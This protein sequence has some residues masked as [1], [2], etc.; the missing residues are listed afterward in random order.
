MRLK[1]DHTC[2][3]L[4]KASVGKEVRINGW[5]NTRRDLGGIFFVDVRDRYGLVQVRFNNDLPS[6]I[7]DV[8]KHLNNE[9]VIA[10][11][12]IVVERPNDSVNQKI[13][14]GEIEIE[15]IDLELLNKAITTPFEITKRETGS[16]DLRLKYRYLDLRTETLKK[17]MHMRHKASQAVRRYLND[18]N[19]MEIE[20][21]VLMKSTP[22]G[23]RDFL[24]PS[25][26][27]P[28]RFY[29]LPQSPQT[30]K[31]LLM[32][33]GYDKYYQIVKC[34]RDEDLRADRQPEFTQI[35][36]EMSFVDE[37]DVRTVMEDMIVTVFKE[38][39][40][41]KI[42]TPLPIITFEEAMERYGSDKPDIRFDLEIKN[43]EVFAKETEFSVF[44]NAMDNGGVIRALKVPEAAVFSRK[45]TDELTELAKKY[46]AKGLAF[47]KV[48]EEGFQAGI[49][50][51]INE[52]AG[53]ILLEITE[54][55]EG[56][57]ILFMADEWE[58]ALTALGAVRIFLANEFGLVKKDE[59]KAIW[60]V[61]FPLFEKDAE[62]GRLLARHHPFTSPKL[63]DIDKL[64][65]DP[66]SVKAR[67]YDMALNGY[68]IG[69]GS[70][71]IYEKEL[72]TR[73]FKALGISEEEA[74]EKF[75]FLLSAFEYGAPPHGGIA[76]GFDRLIMV[77]TG[78]SSI[79]DVIAFPKT[80]TAQSPMDGAPSGVDSKQLDELHIQLKK[81]N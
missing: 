57:L 53:S 77:L 56:D 66:M 8:V 16:E 7:L 41:V 60:I 78:E 14:S 29:A 17:N 43:V 33:A 30:Y 11:S 49:S 48:T 63:E 13:A 38:A 18:H 2:G 23:A 39:A 42:P 65:S 36:C 81:D 71:R 59:Y 26:I 76:F 3:E 55:K 6:T 79:R 19:F 46:G 22:E 21:P 51:F 28:G 44:H 9:D 35:D 4:A 72:Q 31:Q 1:R 67:A 15:A 40:G 24:V 62:T 68:E 27:N 58:T 5:V 10:V 47:V 34:F 52:K 69:G 25:R 70:I 61:D 37:N 45:K 50:K 20:T 74:K 54:A 12:G 75:G 64:E 80:T 32:I 73:M